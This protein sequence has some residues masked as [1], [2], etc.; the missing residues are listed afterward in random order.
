MASKATEKR[1]FY[2]IKSEREGKKLNTMAKIK[3]RIGRQENSKHNSNPIECKCTR[4]SSQGRDNK[5]N[6]QKRMQGKNWVDGGC[7]FPGC[8]C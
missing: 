4:L 2:L 6:L 3:P 8:Y 7:C 5:A 1:N